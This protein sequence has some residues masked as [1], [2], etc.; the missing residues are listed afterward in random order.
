MFG[1]VWLGMW[2]LGLLVSIVDVWVGATF[3]ATD[4][5]S[6]STGKKFGGSIFSLVMVGW[7]VCW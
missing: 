5:R 7:L 6:E 4:A 2:M 1:S 3:E